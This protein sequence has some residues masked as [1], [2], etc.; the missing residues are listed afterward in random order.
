MSWSLSEIPNSF[1]IS[2]NKTAQNLILQN[3]ILQN[4]NKNEFNNYMEKRLHQLK[5]QHI[6]VMLTGL[7]TWK[8]GTLLQFQRQE[9]IFQ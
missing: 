1:L 6:T 3:C 7:F 8:W 9:P 2:F 4:G 5:S